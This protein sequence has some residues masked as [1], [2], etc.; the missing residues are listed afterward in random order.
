MKDLKIG[1][2]WIPLCFQYCTSDTRKPFS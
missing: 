1:G 2:T